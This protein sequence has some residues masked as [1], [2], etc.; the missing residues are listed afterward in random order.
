VLSSMVLAAPVPASAASTAPYPEVTK[1]KPKHKTVDAGETFKASVKAKNSSATTSRAMPLT[2]ILSRTE[3]PADGRE[4]RT[5]TMP[6]ISP[7]DK[8]KEKFTV[9]VP[10]SQPP[11]EYL[12]LVGRPREGK[13]PSVLGK[14]KL[15]V[16]SDDSNEGD[17]ED[18]G[19]SDPGSSGGVPARVLNLT[20]WKL[21]L[22]FGKKSDDASEI[23]QPELNSYQDD[24]AF[25]VD[26]SGT[27]VVFRANAGGA[28]TS[29]ST[30]PR[31]ELRE[32]TDNGKKNAAWSSKSGVHVM[33]VTEAITATPAAKPHVVAAQI[34]DAEDDVVMVRLERN[35]LF[36][37]ADG[38]EVGV[39]DPNY[40]LGTR[41]AVELRAT[42]SG[43]RVTYNGSRVVT[44]KKSGTGYYFK[45]GCYTQSN[46]DRGDKAS[47]YGEV[48]VYALHV[49]HS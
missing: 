23:K 15:K 6:A 20:N 16:E 30:Y 46:V 11:G 45:A 31:S 35:R 3:S 7:D 47:A 21:T 39:L 4:L 38:D 14:V 41:F 24:T 48:V 26:R 25:H 2:F 36:V 33:T 10:S 40:V 44:Y 13:S 43:I 42:S 5:G 49:Q 32:M 22:P 8:E 19:T 1:V 18:G 9:T 37:E 17:G 27:G 12:L 29:G 28:T 34:H